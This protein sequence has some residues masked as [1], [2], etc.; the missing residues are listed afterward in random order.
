MPSPSAMPSRRLSL[1]LS[2]P[3]LGLALSR[4]ERPVVS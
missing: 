1:S 2:L 4:L 3:R